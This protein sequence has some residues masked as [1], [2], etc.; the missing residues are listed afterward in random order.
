MP[1]ELRDAMV[2]L[3]F[4]VLH[5]ALVEALNS[6]EDRVTVLESLRSGMEEIGVKF[7]SGEY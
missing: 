2:R 7:E 3:D 1:D 6:D 4:E 5:Q